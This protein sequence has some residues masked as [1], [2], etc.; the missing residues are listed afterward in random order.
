MTT[1][2]PIP[3]A[4]GT[5]PPWRATLLTLSL[6]LAGVGTA[7]HAQTQSNADE[8]AALGLEIA[9][10]AA[11]AQEKPRAWS[12]TSEV[13]VI[14][15]QGRNGWANES[16]TRASVALRGNYQ[17]TEATSVRYSA[18]L[19]AFDTHVNSFAADHDRTASLLELYVTH[20]ISRDFS[21][22]AGRINV[23]EGN[24]YTF[25]PTDYYRANSVK[26]FVNPSPLVI[27]ESRQGTFSL[28][29]L[30]L[31]PQGAL[32]VL[33]SPKLGNPGPS[34]AWGLDSALT[35][36]NHS[37]LVTWSR[38]LSEKTNIKLLGFKASDQQWQLGLSGSTLVGNA[39]TLHAEA[40]HGRE[41]GAAS[42]PPGRIANQWALGGTLTT[43]QWSWTLEQA[44]NGQA[45]TDATFGQWMVSQPGAAYTYLS[46]AERLQSQNARRNW[47]LYVSRP[48]F[49]W[50]R[51]ELRGFVRLNPN[52]HGRMAW[53]ELRRKF[54]RFDLGYQFTA[55]QGSATSMYG[56]TPARRMHQ[57]VLTHYL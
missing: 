56:I 14:A 21:L 11:E 42:A 3:K 27:R 28:R 1:H 2:L 38:T 16:A 54:D 46:S 39:L 6:S 40:S 41:V 8:D 35:N 19:D 34:G 33:Y 20:A 49:I 18:R 44:Y 51:V 13:G 45:V 55:T 22:Q 53:L 7:A 17:P 9:T 29:G 48:D 24:A 25:N 30:W 5:M 10:P 31:Q 47:L 37:L 57:V 32:S 43:G 4:T 23:R 12:L 50:P 15:T 52:D 36:P 26:L